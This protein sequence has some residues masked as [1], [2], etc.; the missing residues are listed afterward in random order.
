[1]TPRSPTPAR[2]ER[3][4]LT[5]RG[6]RRHI[7]MHLWRI[8]AQKRAQVTWSEES[9]GYY[10]GYCGQ[11]VKAEWRA[12]GDYSPLFAAIRTKESRKP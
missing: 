8:D 7:R 3:P 9:S 6:V 11:K 1:M 2:R 4:E 10:A 12:G 5:P